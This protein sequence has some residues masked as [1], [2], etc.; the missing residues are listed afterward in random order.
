M[1]PKSVKNF[2]KVKRKNEFVCV[3]V[4]SRE[5]ANFKRGECNDQLHGHG[6]D[7]VHLT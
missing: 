4:K 5:K 6:F 7:K 3:C 1:I 2:Y